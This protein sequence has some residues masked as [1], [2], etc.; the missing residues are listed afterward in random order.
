MCKTLFCLL[1]VTLPQQDFFQCKEDPRLIRAIV[2][3][4]SR[5]N[6]VVISYAGA[7]GLMQVMPRSFRRWCTR[8][9]P[10]C[11]ALLL[12]AP[13]N[14]SE[15]CRVLQR[16]KRRARG[17]LRRSLQAYNCGNRGLRDL[18]GVSYA[19]SVLRRTRRQ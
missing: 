5:G 9:D 11:S 15:G 13:L 4:E 18:C 19:N 6:P 14:L 2:H 10:L 7:V 16:W 12:Y 17:N 3:V 8:R 1:F